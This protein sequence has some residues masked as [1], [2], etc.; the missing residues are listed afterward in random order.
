MDPKKIVKEALKAYTEPKS[1]VKNDLFLYKYSYYIKRW[2]V[3]KVLKDGVWAHQLD[4]CKSS[5][6][7]I[8]FSDLN[9]NT[10]YRYYGRMSKLKAFFLL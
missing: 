7:F 8:K 9:N 5:S 4:W 10:G 3:H 6:I 1:L 2:R